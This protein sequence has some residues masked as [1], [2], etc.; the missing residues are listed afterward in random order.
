MV[1]VEQTKEEEVVKEV[2]EEEEEGGKEEE[3]GEEE[4]AIE[5]HIYGDIYPPAAR[6][7]PLLLTQ[8]WRVGGKGGW[9]G[10]RW[11]RGRE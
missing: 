9:V 5:A 2:K 4:E 8:G 11:V 1:A 3:E 10:R 6:P 7:R